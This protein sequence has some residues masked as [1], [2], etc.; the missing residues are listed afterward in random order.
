MG[1]SGSADPYHLFTDPDPVDGRIWICAN[2]TLKGPDPGGPKTSLPEHSSN[3]LDSKQ[4]SRFLS[5]Y[6]FKCL[7]GPQS[8][9]V[10]C[11]VLKFLSFTAVLQIVKNSELTRLL[12]ISKPN[13][14]L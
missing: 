7:D 2:E 9:Y 14:N 1:C 4:R 6:F 3:V 13:I 11:E 8:L 5:Q 10:F 12:A